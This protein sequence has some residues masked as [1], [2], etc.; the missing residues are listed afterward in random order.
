MQFC[1]GGIATSSMPTDIRHDET[2]LQGLGVVCSMLGFL[3]REMYRLHSSFLRRLAFHARILFTIGR[4][5]TEPSVNLDTGHA[6]CDQSLYG[7]YK[8]VL[9]PC[10]FGGGSEKEGSLMRMCTG[11]L[12]NAI[13][14][15]GA[16]SEP[17]PAVC[18]A[19]KS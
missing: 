7:R 5:H 10:C 2:H 19:D 18:S 16:F 13:R 14:T 9:R 4:V 17:Q 3:D 15:N 8:T 11:T 6:S 12:E 1:S